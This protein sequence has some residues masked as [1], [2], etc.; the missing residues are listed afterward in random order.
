MCQVYLHVPGICPHI[1]CHVYLHSSRVTYIS[2]CHVY[3][4]MSHTSPHITC[5]LNLVTY[6]STRHMPRNSQ[7]VTYISSCH[8]YLQH[9]PVARDGLPGGAPGSGVD[10]PTSFWGEGNRN[11]AYCTRVQGAVQCVQFTLYLQYTLS[12]VHFPT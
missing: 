6:I 11:T 10:R 8:I 4:H 2:T 5:H 9:P 3:L 12:A 7:R 1:A